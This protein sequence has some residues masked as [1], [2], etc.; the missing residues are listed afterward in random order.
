VNHENA[1]SFPIKHGDVVEVK[2]SMA[3]KPMITVEGA[4]NGKPSTGTEPRKIQDQLAVFE[5]PYIHGITVLQLL[6]MLGGPSPLALG[7]ESFVIRYKTQE[8]VPVNVKELWETRGRELDVGLN[9]RDHV[10]IPI[11][12][13][14]VLVGGEVNRPGAFPFFN[15]T[16]VSDYLKLAGGIDFEKA[17][18]DGIYFVDD[19]GNRTRVSLDTE[20]IPGVVLYVDRSFFEKTTFI[21]GKIGIIVGLFA[22]IVSITANVTDIYNNLK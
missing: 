8:K 19:V 11:R 6:D 16:I 10:V 15:N 13:I 9:P 20:M 12:N 18:P 5:I 2:S 4:V 1:G 17:D 22:S 7:E 21:A 14:M 3:N